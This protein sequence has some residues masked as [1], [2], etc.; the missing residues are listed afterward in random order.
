MKRSMSCALVALVG[1]GWS[2]SA[3]AQDVPTEDTAPAPT[4]S[5]GAPQAEDGTA[6]GGLEEIIVTAQKRSQNLQQVPIVV[7]SI[8]GDAARAR[9]IDATTD[10]PSIAPGLQF[11]R[12]INA[13]LVFM[14]GVGGGFA[15]AGQEG[16]V[17]FYLDDIY[18][19]S[20]NANMFELNNIDRVEVLSG[21]QGTLFGR[22]AVGGVIQVITKDPSD[23][24]SVDARFGFGSYDTVRADLYATTGI[25]PNLAADI[26]LLY[27]DQGDGFG[28]N[29]ATGRD[30]FKSSAFSARSKLLWTP[31]SDTS[32][33]FSLL[34]DRYRSDLGLASRLL[35]GSIGRDGST[36]PA[37]FYD[38]NQ[39]LQS[40]NLNR[41]WLASARFM[42]DFGGVQLKNVTSYQDNKTFGV[43]D[44][45]QTPSLINEHNPIRIFSKT[46]TNELQ[47]SAD[48]PGGVSWIAGLYVLDN[49][50]D[51][52]P[53]RIF[54]N[55]PNIF[56]T[57]FDLITTLDT[58]SYAGYAQATIP[59]S[60]AT[61]VTGGLRYTY[62]KKHVSGGNVGQNG[63]TTNA[64]QKDSWEKVTYRLSLDHQFSPD[65]LG[66]VSYNRGF[67]AGTFNST[68]PADPG[69]APEVL[70]DFEAGLKTQL[71]DRR[72]RL[73]VAGFYYSYDDI[74][75]RQVTP[76]GIKLLNAAKSEH[77]GIDASL[78]AAVTD[79]F[80]IQA[81]MEW[82]HAEFK[83]FPGAPATARNPAGGNI[84]VTTEFAG[85]RV[86]S[87]PKFVG[88]I[89]AQYKIETASGDFNLAG[90]FNYND[91]FI[92][93][94]E[95]DDRTR[96]KAYATLNLSLTWTDPSKHF[97]I[98]LWGKN[99]TGTKYNV[100][101]ITSVNGDYGT[102]G[103]PATYGVTFGLHF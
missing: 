81:G 37:D 65:V 78:E 92:W 98:R 18:V 7:S 71:F 88:S 101:A 95:V 15:A 86:L 32:L 66:Y 41:Q 9:G 80:R 26:S 49:K 50:S 74:Q 24:T 83:S 17:A 35:P 31:S 22:N 99:V 40:S 68:A 12:T 103:D 25:A 70:D 61:N 29:L 62:D 45:D 60:D 82:L 47:L 42:H 33:Q 52:N 97:D 102:P 1:M 100:F 51:Y 57:Y 89:G 58:R 85:R 34:Y 21:P 72:V 23:T 69:V 38:V 76:A 75:V 77:Y 44:I 54:S 55:P 10:L 94:F 64:S 93:S 30:V 90:N 6:S 96:E 13:G 59:L 4:P 39:N 84:T 36:G 19:Y 11:N 14:R 87:A 73:N 3:V 67:K 79:E 20:L 53:A 91:G 27:S 2:A 63:F 28:R 46:W 8:S 48:N 5:E 43:Y 16:P 56:G